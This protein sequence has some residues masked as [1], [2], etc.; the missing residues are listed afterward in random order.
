MNQEPLILSPAFQERIWGGHKL[1]DLFGYDIPSDQ[2]GEAWIISAHRNGPSQVEN[3]ALAGKTLNVVWQEHPELFG[4]EKANE[5]FPLL[6]KLLDANADLSVQVHPNDTYA[7]R[8]EGEPYGKTE[9]WYVVDCEDNAEIVFGHHAKSESEF[10]EMVEAG[11]WDDLLRRVKVNKGDFIYVP[12][13]TIHAIGKGIVILETQQSSDI[14]YRVYDYGRTDADGNER[15]LHIDASIA[16]THYPHHAEQQEH[17]TVTV[18]GLTKTKLVQADYFTVYHL[19]VDGAATA[20][21]KADYILMS[22]LDGTGTLVVNGQDYTLEKGTNLIL[23]ATVAS[24]ELKGRM[25]M[26]VSHETQ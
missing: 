4:K 14:T 21:V 24:Y 19:E 18:E 25:E 16:V 3:G 6:V 1:K 15:E 22:V 17:E 26:I 20:P 12:S 2:T 11:E 10:R 7:R 8:V 5:A 9:C 23:P 13:G